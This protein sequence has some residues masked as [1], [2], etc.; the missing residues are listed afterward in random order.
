MVIILRA[1]EYHRTGFTINNRALLRKI[2]LRKDCN[3]GSQNEAN[4]EKNEAVYNMLYGF[5]FCYN[6]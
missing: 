5:I 1:T 3:S 6:A 4:T 2:D